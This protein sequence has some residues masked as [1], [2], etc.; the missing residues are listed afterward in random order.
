MELNLQNVKGTKDYMPEEQYTRNMIKN[1]L[2]NVF[3]RYGCKPLETP[4]LNYYEVMASKYAGGAEILKEMYSVKNQGERD[5]V[6]RYD[7]T[8]PFAKVVGMNPNLRMPFKRYEIG[9]V[10]RDGPVKTGRL[11]EFNQ[12]DVDVVG[13]KSVMAE[14]ELMAMAI[15][16]FNELE[17]DVY[18][19]YN[20]RKLLNGMIS[21]LNI[22]NDMINSV[23]LT[24]DKI[25]KLSKD[26]IMKELKEKN[27]SEA[28]IFDLFKIIDNKDSI[29]LS[30][31]EEDELFKNNSLVKDGIT[32][33]KE[34]ED[35]LNALGIKSETKFNPF[36]A[37]GLDIY[38]G[39]VY[40]IFLKDS[41]IK[42]SIG[43]GGRYDKIIGKFLNSEKD[44]PAVG[45][46][47]GLDV[48]F[49]ALSLKNAAIRKSSTKFFVIP[50]GTEKECLKIVQSIRRKGYS[51]QMEMSKRRL[52]N[53]LDYVNKEG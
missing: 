31:F 40:E 5:L 3:L 29:D 22:E 17:L 42:S 1:T 28:A 52:R 21:S 43:S 9:K 53:S 18:I 19:S 30:Y 24:L 26:E 50:L 25:E 39:T 33:L 46:S 10:F 37:R 15:D 7:L 36:L 44:Y 8:I 20:N 16:I 4:I 2:E 11:R 23:I 35:L 48:I 12:C 41:T 45:I 6:L 47:F 32:E 34:L 27:I 38:T 51:A 14:A 13:I 49:A